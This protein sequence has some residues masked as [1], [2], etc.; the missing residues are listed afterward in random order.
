[1][2]GNVEE[3][4]IELAPDFSSLNVVARKKKLILSGG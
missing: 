1:V 2:N 3:Y 4:L